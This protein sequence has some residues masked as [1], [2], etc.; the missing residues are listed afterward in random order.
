M[1]NP[2]RLDRMVEPRF[3]AIKLIPDLEKFLFKG[4]ESIQIT[5]HKSFSSITLHA[6]DIKITQAALRNG[7]EI[8]AR[9]ITYNEKFETATL[10]FGKRLKSGNY[11]LDLEF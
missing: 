1:R 6:L 10:H 7:S 3:Y 2:Y 5:A 9:H 11:T 4:S 8:A